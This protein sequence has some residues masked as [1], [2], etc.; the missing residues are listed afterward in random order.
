MHAKCVIVDERWSLIG[1]A[2]FTD[3][4]HTRNIE[5]VVLLDDPIFAREVLRQF[6][7]A[8]DLGLFVRAS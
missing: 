6:H 8:R 7:S 5:V 1:S 2:N 4:G 3:R